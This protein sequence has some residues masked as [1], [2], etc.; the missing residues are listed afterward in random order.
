MPGGVKESRK[1]TLERNDARGKG[2]SARTSDEGV[3]PLVVYACYYA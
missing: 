3:V 1:G 2:G